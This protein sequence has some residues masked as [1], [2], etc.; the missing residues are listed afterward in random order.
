MRMHFISRLAL[1]L[2]A[3]VLVVATQVWTMNTVSWLFVVGGIVMLFAAA[4][5]AEAPGSTQRAL[6]A[7]I[8]VLGL[9]SVIQ[10]IVLHGSALQW[11]SFGTGVALALL[12]AL[13]LAIHE[14]STERIV[15]E[16]SVAPERPRAPA[17]MPFPH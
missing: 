9:F 16:L 3:E 2:I 7:V 5:D 11:C 10:A 1:L 4:I 17:A 8:A 13:G 12:A 6:D 15:H 14:T